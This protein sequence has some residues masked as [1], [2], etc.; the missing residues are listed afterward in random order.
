MIYLVL[1]FSAAACWF[2]LGKHWAGVTQPLAGLAFFLERI[3][4]AARLPAR[5]REESIAV[6]QT[7]V[8]MEAETKPCAD[9]NV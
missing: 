8:V 4:W 3:A 5:R 7:R 2:P 9:A 6:V 1:V